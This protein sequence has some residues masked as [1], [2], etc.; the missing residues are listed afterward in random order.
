MAL[1]ERT[2]FTYDLTLALPHLQASLLE[3]PY[4]LGIATQQ[5]QGQRRPQTRL[6]LRD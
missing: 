2:P 3:S 5:C 6:N 4:A 1:H